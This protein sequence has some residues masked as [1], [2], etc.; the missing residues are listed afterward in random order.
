LYSYRRGVLESRAVDEAV[1]GWFPSGS[2]E[3]SVPSRLE[4]WRPILERG[5]TLIG[6]FD[7]ETLAGIAIYR[8]H[9]AEGTANLAVLHVS[10]I[11]RR[12]G[13]ASLLTDEVAR[14]ARADG[15]R[16][17]YVSATPSES[18]VGF[19]RSHGFVPTDEPDEA[20]FALEPEDIHMLLEL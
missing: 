20:L 5:G 16:R 19:Y 15:A 6:A 12:K 11:H 9:L 17:L 7:G 8:P 18:A 10:R 3:H 4:A 1:P 14:L 2:H 13:I